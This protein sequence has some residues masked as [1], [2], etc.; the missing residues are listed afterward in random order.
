MKKPLDPRE[1]AEAILKRSI[2][3]VKV[4][5]VL[6]DKQGIFAWGWNHMGAS[7]MGI[8]AEVHCL[9]RAN[10]AR[11]RDAVMYIAGERARNG[12]AV[13]ARPCADCARATAFVGK[14]IWRDSDHSW[15]EIK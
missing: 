1:L 14:I 12:K 13:P 6:A 9:S 11:L 8:H 10:K 15:K 2:C 3:N 7:G 5:A 4:G